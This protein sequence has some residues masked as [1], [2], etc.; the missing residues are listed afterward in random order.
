MKI[1]LADD[2]QI[3]RKIISGFLARFGYQVEVVNDG[4]EAWNLLQTPNSPQL[5][6]ATG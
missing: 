2:D 6:I 4:M 1:I 5:A 3:S